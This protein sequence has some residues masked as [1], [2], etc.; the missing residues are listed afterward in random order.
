MTRWQ[1]VRVY[2][3]NA[4]ASPRDQDGQASGPRALEN[5]DRGRE[6]V[7]AAGIEAVFRES[8]LAVTALIS[9]PA[10]AVRPCA[11]H[12]GVT[13]SA[14]FHIPSKCSSRRLSLWPELRR[15]F[16]TARLA[17]AQAAVPD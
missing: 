6:L 3:H 17:T 13:E 15:E 16:R 5:A 4:Q 11:A 14:A 10:R 1:E 2:E 12:P 9:R 7:E 8:A